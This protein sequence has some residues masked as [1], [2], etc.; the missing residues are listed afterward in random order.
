MTLELCDAVVDSLLGAVH[1][2]LWCRRLVEAARLATWASVVLMLLA[3]AVIYFAK[4]AGRL[5]AVLLAL[6]ILWASALG[7]V[8]LRR[9]STDACALWADQQ[10]AGASAYSTLLDIRCRKVPQPSLDAAHCLA[11]WLT[12]NVP[13]A[14]RR[15]RAEPDRTH[16]ARPVLLMIVSA[17]LLMAVLTLP[18]VAPETRVNPAAPPPQSASSH[19]AVPQAP[20]LE[21]GGLVNELEAALKKG[22]SRP[23]AVVDAAGDSDNPRD[24]RSNEPTGAGADRA[25]ARKATGTSE[26]TAQESARK[27]V[28]NAA[29]EPGFAA[30]AAASGHE[31]GEARDDGSDRVSRSP[32][33]AISFRQREVMARSA[34]VARRADMTQPAAFEDGHGVHAGTRTMSPLIGSAALPPAAENTAPLTPTQAAYVQAW[35]KMQGSR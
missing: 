3:V 22:R 16:L 20:A 9:P 23:A 1:R 28:A 13:E 7:W 31:A 24:M 26:N 25:Q 21:S 32:S 10:L 6:G 29:A 34:T 33:E 2:R 14:R 17:A 19:M 15:L 18:G 5:E 35:L 27:D 4:P 12:A 8:L 30:A 11:R